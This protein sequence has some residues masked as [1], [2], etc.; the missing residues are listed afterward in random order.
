MHTQMWLKIPIYIIGNITANLIFCIFFNKRKQ[1]IYRSWWISLNNKYISAND[2][3]TFKKITTL[4]TYFFL[5]S[6]L[7]I[8]FG[9]DNNTFLYYKDT[10]QIRGFCLFV[11]KH[12]SYPIFFKAWMYV[13]TYLLFFLLNPTITSIFRCDNFTKN[14]DKLFRTRAGMQA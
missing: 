10:N 12:T 9:I 13:H 8:L 4:N 6:S 5:V 3:S 14:C 1:V 11:K 2:R 7:K